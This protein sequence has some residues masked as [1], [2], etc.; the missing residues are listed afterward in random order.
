MTMERWTTVDSLFSPA[1]ARRTAPKQERERR[2]VLA[3]Y[4]T[5]ENGETIEKDRRAMANH[6]LE[7]LVLKKEEIG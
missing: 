2:S 5:S 7:E 6:R 1:I 4:T 3:K